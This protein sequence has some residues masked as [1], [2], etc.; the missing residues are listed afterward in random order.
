MERA[1]PPRVLVAGLGNIFLGDDAFG[2]EVVKRISQMRVPE[3]VRV[4]DAGIR[5]V[6]LAYELMEGEY[7]TAILI[8]IVSKGGAPGTVYLLEPESDDSLETPEAPNGHAIQPHH[9][10]ALVRRLGGRVGRVLI[11]GCEPARVDEESGLSPVV[12]AAVDEAARRVL[13][14]VRT[15]EVESLCA[16]PGD[17][18]AAVPTVH[19]AGA[20]TPEAPRE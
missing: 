11:V 5:T 1:K 18:E 19:A 3:S 9:V 20:W 12:A 2:V 10:L 16:R 4:L 17:S 13:Q 6:H 8:D 14:L 15:P 7:D